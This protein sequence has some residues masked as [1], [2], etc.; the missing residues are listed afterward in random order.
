MS[1][2]TG[3]AGQRDPDGQIKPLDEGCFCGKN[4][5][6]DGVKDRTAELVFA[7]QPFGGSNAHRQTGGQDGWEQE[8]VEECQALDLEASGHYHLAELPAGVTA[9][10]MGHVVLQ[11]PQET[12]CGDERDQESTGMDHAQELLRR[13]D[14]IVEVLK[15]VERHHQIEATGSKR[16]RP[17]VAAHSGGVTPFAGAM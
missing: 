13:R 8:G 1:R 9:T 16:Q 2:T 5:V 6:Q 4:G 12:E 17:G 14:V 3:D 15:H 11:A 10:M 7:L